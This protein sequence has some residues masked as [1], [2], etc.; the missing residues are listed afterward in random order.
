MVKSKFLRAKHEK[1]IGSI[2]VFTDTKVIYIRIIYGYTGCYKKYGFT[3]KQVSVGMG[4]SPDTLPNIIYN[5]RNPQYETLRKIADYL[6]CHISEFFYDEPITH[7]GEVVKTEDSLEIANGQPHL[8]IRSV[9]RMQ[10]V[11]SVALGILFSWLL[12]V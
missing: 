6:G 3:V 5:T 11:T 10:G 7:H 8:R 12:V 4:Y 2:F 1:I 9:M